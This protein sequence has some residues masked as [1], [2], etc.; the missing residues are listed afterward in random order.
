MVK[1][2]L[3]LY[4]FDELTQGR[5]IC[6][7]EIICDYHISERTFMR[8]ISEIR[9]YMYNFYRNKELVFSKSDNHYYLK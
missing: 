8:Y 3:V 2:Q 5:G 6:A 7:H 9:A 1:S 4:L